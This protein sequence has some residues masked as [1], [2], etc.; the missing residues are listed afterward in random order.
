MRNATETA[1]FSLFNTDPAAAPGNIGVPAREILLKLVPV[2]GKWEARIKGPNVTPGYWRNPGLT[3]EAFDDEGFYCFG[4][5]LRF[6]DPDDPGKGFFFDG[7][8]AENFKMSTGTWVAVGALRAKLTDALGGLA[9]DA[10]IVGEQADELGALL[11]PFRPAIEKLVP[12]GEDMADDDLYR[13][14]VLR[15]ALA[16]RLGAYNARATGA[17]L[18]VPRVMV[19]TDPLSIELGEVTDKG[20]V[21]QRAVRTHRRDLVDSLYGGDKRVILG[22]KE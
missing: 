7:R 16:A 18:R 21:N 10:V 20:S 1:P 9:R 5:A 2:E 12:G 14:P 6:A 22:S 13:H 8:V 17:S 4:D 3:A 11:V 19:M 15:E